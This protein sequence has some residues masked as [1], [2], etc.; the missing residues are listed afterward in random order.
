MRAGGG[1][2]GLGTGAKISDSKMNTNFQREVEEERCGGRG[3]GDVG[4]GDQ[5]VAAKRVAWSNLA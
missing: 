5:G 1:E 2:G 4:G 3:W